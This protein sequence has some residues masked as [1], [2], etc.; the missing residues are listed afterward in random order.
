MTKSAQTIVDLW[1]SDEA[2]PLWFNSTPEF[3]TQLK[4]ELEEIYLAA[5]NDQLNGW[6]DDAVG[7]LALVILF[8]QIPLNIFRNQNQAFATEARARQVAQQAIDMGFDRGLPK[9]QKMF[10]YLPFMHSE[11]P[12]DQETSVA[13]FAQAEMPEN[14]RFAIHHR[15]IIKRFGR[16]PHRNSVLEREST[17]EEIEY[18]NSDEAFRG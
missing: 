3:D 17:Q 5:K 8:D 1:F 10:F 13:L 14:V 15:D 4:Q 18:L 2:R 12:G 9:E 16:F 6:Q 7:A 11:D